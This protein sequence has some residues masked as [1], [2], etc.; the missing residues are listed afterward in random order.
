VPK[1]SE[2]ITT[3]TKTIKIQA[4]DATGIK[5]NVETIDIVIHRAGNGTPGFAAILAIAAIL[6]ALLFMKKMR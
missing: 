6:I 2:N 3:A 5:S 1:L 4:T